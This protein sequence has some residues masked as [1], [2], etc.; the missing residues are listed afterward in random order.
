M[1]VYVRESDEGVQCG[2][3]PSRIL[4]C[5]MVCFERWRGVCTQS[6]LALIQDAEFKKYVVEYAKDNDKFKND[7]AAAWKKL[8][9]FGVPF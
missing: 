6:D 3:H 2:V 1:C 4:I 5:S 9:E 7:F 8:I